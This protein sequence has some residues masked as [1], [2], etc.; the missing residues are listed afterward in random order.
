MKVGSKDH[1]K[2]KRLKRALDIPLY[3]ALGILET[4][5]QSAAQSADDGAIGRFS[6]AD[7]AL[8]LEWEG[9]ADDLI[10]A[11]VESGLLDEHKDLRLVIHDWEDHAP[12]FIKDRLRKRKQTTCA[13]SS[14]GNSGDTRNDET[15]SEGSR[16][17]IG[18]SQL[19]I[20][21]PSQPNQTKPNHGSGQ[22]G[23]RRGGSLTS[24]TTED[25]AD[26][27]KVLQW[28]RHKFGS[29]ASEDI[30]VFAVAAAEAALSTKPRR[31]PPGLFSSIVLENKR[32]SV[33]NAQLD[34]ASK[35]IRNALPR[36][37]PLAPVQ[38]LAAALTRNR[39]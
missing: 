9:D 27:A 13:Q 4:L 2:V 17:G 38:S 14:D 29:K 28:V 5:Y 7:I 15:D 20:P 37:E 1:I 6:N 39:D 32:S 31:N 8:E 23:N 22:A 12:N 21:N 16:N 26:T 30:Q 3:Q 19:T 35:R 24:L 11:L 34:N 18:N 36:G 25:L 33:T 10:T